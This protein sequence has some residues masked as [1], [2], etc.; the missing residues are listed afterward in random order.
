MLATLK[1]FFAIFCILLALFFIFCSPQRHSGEINNDKYPVAVYGK[2]TLFIR[3]NNG[4]TITLKKE[5]IQEIYEWLLIQSL[6]ETF[7]KNL[8]DS[9]KINI[10]QRLEDCSNEI[11]KYGIL[12]HLLHERLKNANIEFKNIP[13]IYSKNLGK[14]ANYET[15]VRIIGVI[16]TEDLS[17]DDMNMISQAITYKDTSALKSKKVIKLL[18][19]KKIAKIFYGKE[20][21][22]WKVLASLTTINE[23]EILK[24]CSKEEIFKFKVG[25]GVFIGKVVE[26]QRTN[27]LPSQETISEYIKTIH[28]SYVRDSL[29]KLIKDSIIKRAIENKS[30]KILV[31]ME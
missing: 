31:K 14:I 8:P 13:A 4:D 7:Y 2:E 9:I 6:K 15:I 22:S 3:K 23:E 30:A 16:T 5:E 27:K 17:E 29:M 11:I 19:E 24:F 18:E 28:M 12:E 26:C 25:K 1:E 21:Y 10:Q 20:W